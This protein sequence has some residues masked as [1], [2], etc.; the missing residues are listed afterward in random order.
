MGALTHH[1]GVA[2]RLGWLE[3]GCWLTPSPYRSSRAGTIPQLTGCQNN[4]NNK[5]AKMPQKLSQ[6]ISFVTLAGPFPFIVAL[7]LHLQK[8][9]ILKNPAIL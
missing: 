5:T 9:K 8:S 4:N 1:Q 6:N 7:I 2:E 3:N